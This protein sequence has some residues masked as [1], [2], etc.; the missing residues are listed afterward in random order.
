MGLDPISTHLPVSILQS[1][2]II[3]K[4]NRVTV[5][6]LDVE[7]VRVRGSEVFEGGTMV[8][9]PYSAFLPLIDL[10]EV[11]GRRAVKPTELIKVDRFVPEGITVTAV[12]APRLQRSIQV[13]RLSLQTKGC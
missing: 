1:E 10:R 11:F 13:F 7:F 8:C 4:N 9:P 2:D 3:L 12:R 5:R 6:K